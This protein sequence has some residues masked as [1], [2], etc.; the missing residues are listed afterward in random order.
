MMSS[1]SSEKILHFKDLAPN[2]FAVIQKTI[3]KNKNLKNLTIIPTT[4]GWT[5][6]PP[7]S[8]LP[9]V[10]NRTLPSVPELPKEITTLTKLEYLSIINMG[11]TKLPDNFDRLFN[12][13]VLNLSHNKLVIENEAPKFEKLQNLEELTIYWNIADEK[14][15]E[16]W[17]AKQSFKVNY[18]PNQSDGS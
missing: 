5:V 1:C 7:L 8:A 6:Y 14:F 9:T 15:L 11:L 4:E 18:N 13:K 3:H 10:A 17:A 16:S 2:P 12:L